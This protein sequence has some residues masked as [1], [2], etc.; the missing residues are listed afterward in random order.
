M[1]DAPD[2]LGS[3]SWA[4]LGGLPPW[5]W[6]VVPAVLAGGIV[7]LEF[8]EPLLSVL[9]GL[10]A[11]ASLLG[12]RRLPLAVLAVTGT[13]AFIVII[14]H[15]VPF[16]PIEVTVMVALYT[17]D[18]RCGRRW[19][20]AASAVAFA[21][22]VLA[23]ALSREVAAGL[24]PVITVAPA[25]VITALW[26][27]GDNLRVRRA[28]VAGLEERAAWVDAQRAADA[29][30]AAEDERARIARELH[31]V[32][33][34]HV[35]V[36]AV[37]AGAAR[38]LTATTD[39]RTRDLLGS[40]E[41]ASHQAMSELRRLLGV[42]R[43]E[44]GGEPGGPRRPG[45]QPGLA[46]LDQ[47]VD[48]VR[49]AG[50]PVELTVVGAPGGLPD[51]VD[52]SAYRI[53]QEALTNALKHAGPVPTQV[54]LRCD[55]TAATL[56]VTNQAPATARAAEPGRA[57]HGLI[58]MRERAVMAGGELRAGPTPDGGFEVFARLP[59]EPG[60]PVPPQAQSAQAQSAQAQSAQAQSAGDR[61]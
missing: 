36:I 46:Q 53:V 57:G 10:V 55:D 6:D 12:R 32:V 16:T 42:L 22:A 28:Y 2:R 45:P 18:T 58:G 40:I 38:M 17:V 56:V 43:R 24:L 20:L 50:L 35:A 26:V 34:H 3:R 4:W 61:R 9:L 47:L 11:A 1:S 37:Q 29:R 15:A 31:D 59:L 14:V 21:G 19:S 39:E 23:A 13:A 49:R 54:C 7:A 30:R 52:L 25:A 8:R 51:G 5:T 27:T 41:G 33:A 44:P 48:Q 60:R